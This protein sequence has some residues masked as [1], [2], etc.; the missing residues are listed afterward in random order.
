M[1]SPRA[2]EGPRPRDLAATRIERLREL[3]GQPVHQA[4]EV[5]GPEARRGVARL[6]PGE[7]LV[8]ENTRWEPGETENDPELAR[9]LAAPVDLYVDDAFGAAHRAH[10]STVGRCGA[11]APGGRGSCWSAR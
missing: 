6:E 9:E 8:L 4:P 5:I 2:P 11:A 7:V 1:L 10:A 3:I